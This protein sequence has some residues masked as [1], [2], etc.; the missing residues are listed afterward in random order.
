MGFRYFAHLCHAIRERNL[1]SRY[2]LV[3]LN[4]HIGDIQT[5]SCLLVYGDGQWI[6]FY[7]ICIYCNRESESQVDL[8]N[9]TY[10]DLE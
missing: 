2:F 6:F 4:C 3:F 8:K 9:Y 1:K 10:Q 7:N 5:Y